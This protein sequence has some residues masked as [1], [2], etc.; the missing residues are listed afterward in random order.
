MQQLNIKD[1]Y[2]YYF[3]HINRIE[4]FE[5]L[6]A[7]QLP[8]A[9]SVP[10][11]DWE[12]FGSILTGSQGTPGHGADLES[13]EIKSATEGSSFEYQYHLHGGIS[14]LDEDMKVDHIFI[15]YSS[16]Y[17]DVTVRLVK[18]ED[19]ATEFES[20]RAGL[21]ENYSGDTPRQRYRKS[22]ALG[23]IRELGQIVV[24]IKDGVLIAK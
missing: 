22:I 5:L 12:L 11:V 14:K 9:G 8:V 23:K 15:S 10:P 4:R 7:H 6:E 18:G 17:R 16:N 2:Q 20:W 24:Q 13:Y 3:K 1:A 19:L 21:L